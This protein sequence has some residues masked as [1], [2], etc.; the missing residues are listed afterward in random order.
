MLLRI[1][2]VLLRR[3]RRSAGLGHR[4]SRSR[5]PAFRPQFIY[6]ED[7]VLLNV[8]PLSGFKGLDTNDAGAVIEPP[9]TIA[10]AG[11]STVVEIV[12][13]N[14]AYYSKATGTRLFTLGLD[15][16]FG[17]VD[18]SP[19]LLSDVYVTYDEGTGKFF[20]STMDIDFF[21]EQS[22]FNYAI[23]NNSDPMQ[24]WQ[25]FKQ[26]NT[27][28]T[29]ERTGEPLF[30]DFPR[31]GWNAD[32][33]VISFN[34]FG[35]TTEVPYNVQILSINKSTLATFQTDRPLPNSTMVPA[36][37]HGAAPGSPMWWVEEKGLEQDG[38][39][40]F[41]RVVKETNILSANPTFTD[42][43]V[44]VNPYTITPFPSDPNGQ[45]TT[46]LDTR[47]LSADWRA[48]QLAAS[49]N[50]GI[51][52]DT[53]VHARWYVLNTNGP[54][55]ALIQEGDL[56]P[57]NG[58]IDTYMPAIA[59]APDGSLGMTYIQSSATEM[60][61][62]YVT[63][64]TPAD[65]PGTMAPGFDAKAGE[66]FYQGTRV[67]DF[68]GITV[69]PANPSIFW[70]ANE[71]S[72]SS[73]DITIPNWGT[74]IASFSLQ[75]GPHFT[76]S[77]PASSAQ[78]APFTITVTALNPDNSTNTGYTGTVHFTS[79]DPAASLPAN[80]TFS[81]ADNGV[82]T[83]T[84]GVTLNTAGTQKVT[85]T[86]SVNGI[87]GIATVAVSASA[88]VSQ[89]ILTGIPSTVSAGSPV[90]FTVK[91]ADSSGNAVPGYRGT[92]HFTSSD[93]HA[94]LPADYTFT[95]ADA[96]V[97]T[98]SV[99][100]KTVGNNQSLTA[101]DKNNA[102]ITG[103]VTN[104]TV[105]PGAATSFIVAGFPSPISAGISGTFT[106]MARD[107]F[108]N[109]AT[110]Y[111]GT[112]KL[113]S[114]DTKAVLPANYTFVAGDAGVHT[115]NATL[116]TAGTRSLT[117]T[118]TVTATI[119]GTQSN[120]AVTA[121][122]A[123]TLTVAGF[124]STTAGV[125]QSFTVTAKDAFGNVASA[126]AG[127]VHFTSSDTKASLPAN[128]SFT[129]VDAGKHVFSATLFTAPTQ[130]ITATDT[131]TAS[132]QGTQSSIRVSA[133]AAVSLMITAFPSSTTAGV[134]HG[135]K[136]AAK[137]QFGN[138]A[139]S[140]RG[141]IHFTSSDAQA[142]LPAD[143]TFVAADAGA[144]MFAAATLK[145]AGSQT[146]TVTDTANSSLTTTITSTVV[147]AAA[148]HLNVSS[149]TSVSANVPFNVVVTALDAFGNVATSYTG[150]VHF[151]SSD[152][153][154]VLPANYTFTSGSGRDNGTHTFSAT[155]KT[156]G[157][158]SISATDTLKASIT[159]TQSGIT[160]AAAPLDLLFQEQ[161][162]IP[163][164]MDDVLDRL[165]DDRLA[166]LLS[167]DGILDEDVPYV[168]RDWKIASAVDGDWNAV[169]GALALVLCPVCSVQRLT[170]R[171]GKGATAVA[172]GRS[173]CN[174]SS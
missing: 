25:V 161:A 149:P 56:D 78:G 154:A 48:G 41:L 111:L 87:T 7:R 103:S 60:M 157:T 28:E 147:A 76:I 152:P 109:I 43:Y 80:Y 15:Q 134:S 40:Q 32:A 33:Y 10:A 128:Y 118:D 120:I 105:N 24:G 169:V 132:I 18:P 5:K 114:S 85:A 19:S 124:P 26:V 84:N 160:V 129:A 125:A 115:F 135:L 170:E 69:D 35:F 127:T 67:G 17:S 73:T 137:D 22:F 58:T 57:G 122:A 90:S 53:V 168:L 23:S 106:V 12:N 123:S 59:M 112:V 27:S 100:F 140:Y 65:P 146:I 81:A 173:W 51:A 66:Q 116:K 45:V 108:G 107:A 98:F 72:I 70:A 141:T 50:V 13:S 31:V 96:G 162:T 11:P 37:M 79:T 8:T 163:E 117:A 155:L 71:Y 95:A 131:V 29:S 167:A 94:T 21:N 47:I 88:A 144:H 102:T 171:R 113:T 139:T 74:W 36:T 99:T 158:Q 159:G 142:V 136:V 156:V 130:S 6:L 164:E 2:L 42:F 110:G 30:T 104:I 101:T 55:P 39:Y 126:Y 166:E 64:Q 63:G 52:S 44:A 61:S 172:V 4:P 75:G 97:H 174:V 145:T 83:F 14:I 143:Y 153:Q 165:P 16:F 3:C 86:D 148:T 133:A 49:Q 150:I 54:A 1:P 138:T 91:A 119:K 77:A 34:M 151:T 38:T 46:Q 62:M 9:D 20:V 92:V 93:A 89:F 121:A 82:H 68:S